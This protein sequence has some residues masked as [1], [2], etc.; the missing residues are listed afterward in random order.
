MKSKGVCYD[1]GRVM[2]G[3]DGRPTFDPHMV[4]RELEIIKS[5]LHC[6]A[7][8][9]CGQDIGRLTLAADDALQQG[10]KVWLS[11]ELFDHSA[12]ET[13][14]YIVTAPE[15]PHTL[16]HQPPYI[17]LPPFPSHLTLSPNLL[18]S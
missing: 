18:T 3:E 4:H 1:V 14:D 15:T 9:I 7:V 12:Q 16:R 10:L 17:L 6:N 13:L 5:D 2:L 8:R 11:P